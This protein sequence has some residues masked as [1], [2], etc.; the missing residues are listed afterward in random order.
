MKLKK[1]IKKLN[2]ENAPP[3][4]WSAADN[5][6]VDKGKP[7]A[8]KIYSLTGGPGTPSIAAGNTWEESLVKD[9]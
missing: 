8:G 6:V 7:V 5:V 1:L 4:G 2:K 3:D 9:E